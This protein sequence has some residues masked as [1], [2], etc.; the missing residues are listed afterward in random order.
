MEM[1]LED[2]EYKHFPSTSAIKSMVHIISKRKFS[3]NAVS[4]L[5]YRWIELAPQ[6]KL[7]ARPGVQKIGT[8][9]DT[10]KPQL[11]GQNGI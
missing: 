11:C 2:V 9:G 7:Q 4:L 5:K 3:V 10:N 1:K 8:D 6:P